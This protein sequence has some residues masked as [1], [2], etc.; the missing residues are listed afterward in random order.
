LLKSAH[1]LEQRARI[2]RQIEDWRARLDPSV[3]HSNPNLFVEPMAAGEKVV[4][5]KRAETAKLIARLYGDAVAVEMEGRGFLGGVH[6]NHSVQG[7]VIRG[8]MLRAKP[9]LPP[10][11][12]LLFATGRRLRMGTRMGLL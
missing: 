4:A 2:I 1:G 8:I 10:L 9:D 7:C 11:S 6:I 3:A 12:P 5:S